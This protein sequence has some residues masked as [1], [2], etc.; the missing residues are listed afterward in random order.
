MFLVPLLFQQGWETG[1]RSGRTKA[2]LEDFPAQLNP[3]QTGKPLRKSG[4]S[5]QNPEA[6]GDLSIGNRNGKVRL[7][8]QQEQP[9]VWYFCTAA[10]CLA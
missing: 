8:K 5:L 7:G 9:S 3:G 4:D 1:I 10:S 6:S 2:I